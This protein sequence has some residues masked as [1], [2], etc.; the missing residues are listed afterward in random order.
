MDQSLSLVTPP[1]NFIPGALQDSVPVNYYGTLVWNG[2]LNQ[3]A[4]Q[5]VRTGATQNQYQAFPARVSSRSSIPASTLP[6][7]R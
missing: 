6:I 1:L 4:N 7:P 5:I 3:P 2:Y